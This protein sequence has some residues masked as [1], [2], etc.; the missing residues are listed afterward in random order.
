MRLL[1][2][3]FQ[4]KGGIIQ[5]EFSCLFPYGRRPVEELGVGGGASECF[6]AVSADSVTGKIAL[7]D[8]LRRLTP[9]R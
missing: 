6:S 3:V 4:K 9:A 2:V 5:V 8:G 1:I 7:L